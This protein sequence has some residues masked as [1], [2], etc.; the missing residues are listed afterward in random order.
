M[1]IRS[2]LEVRQVVQTSKLRNYAF[3]DRVFVTAQQMWSILSGFVM[4][5]PA[6]ANRGLITY[7]DLAEMAGY[8]DRRA[9]RVIGRQ[10]GVIGEFCLQNDLPA[11]NS[12]VV[13]ADSGV[14]GTGVVHGAERSVSEEQEAVL[15]YNWYCIGVP[16][17]GMLRKVWE[18]LA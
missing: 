5:S 7:G 1:P 10:L 12:I 8:A 16:T 15:A 9:G 3:G 14:P 13:R 18:S 2:K 6:A 4:W 11:L 17:T